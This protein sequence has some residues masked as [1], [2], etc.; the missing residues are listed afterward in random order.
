MTRKVQAPPD[1]TPLTEAI[2]YRRCPRCGGEDTI[3]WG[4]RLADQREGYYVALRRCLACMRDYRV[5][6]RA[7][8][9][10]AE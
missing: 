8:R 5:T 10:E 3:N 6:F 9:V 4:H 1:T 7:V 2:D